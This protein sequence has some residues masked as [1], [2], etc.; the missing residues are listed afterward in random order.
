M[1][2]ILTLFSAR[3]NI[4]LFTN[5]TDSARNELSHLKSALFALYLSKY[6][7][8]LITYEKES[9]K[10]EHGRVHFKQFGVE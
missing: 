1:Y 10:F 7:K 3:G 9:P 8:T 6:Y 4:E 5:N 2:I